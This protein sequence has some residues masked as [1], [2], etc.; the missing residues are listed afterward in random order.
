MSA[1]YNICLTLIPVSFLNTIKSSIP[2]FTILICRFYYSMSYP[3][4]TYISL[5]P[6]VIGVALASLGE[7]S[8]NMVGF[9]FAIGS[10]CASTCFNLFA[11]KLMSHPDLDN[12]QIQFYVSVFSLCFLFPLWV[13]L[14]FHPSHN[15][16]HPM[17]DGST[18]EA[19]SAPNSH[20][21][22]LADQTSS[23]EQ[24]LYLFVAG[25]NYYIELVAVYGSINVLGPVAYAVCDVLR[26]LAIIV[27]A[28][29]FFQ[30]EYDF[31]IVWF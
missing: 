4:T 9:I 16:E 14:P 12:L 8:F 18:I 17:I 27:S 15:V 29:I 21:G 23:I 28:V 13:L 19:T 30:N 25:L 10:A 7:L 1:T 5:L 3:W 31:I 26:R 24:F 2:L 20:H 6:I 22:A 11:K